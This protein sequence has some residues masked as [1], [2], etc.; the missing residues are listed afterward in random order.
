M[1]SDDVAGFF[2]GGGRS[3]KFPTVGSEVKGTI[4]KVHPPEQ[5]TDYETRAPIPGKYQIRMELQTAVIDPDIDG[6]DGSRVL[7]VKGWMQGAI[8]DA[9]RA[10]GAKEPLPGADIEVIRVEDG[11]PTRPGLQ[12]PHRFSAVYTPSGGFFTQG[13]GNG[14]AAPAAAAPAAKAQAPIPAAPPA[15]IDPAA[16]DA[17]P[18]AAKQAIANVAAGVGN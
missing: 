5:Q 6:D 7:Y 10:A 17:M 3:V 15:G 13:N 9:L 18:E 11:P 8:G 12:G 14:A 4:T 16:W 2:S 1:S